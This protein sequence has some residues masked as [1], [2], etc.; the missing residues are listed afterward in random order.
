MTDPTVTS[1]VTISQENLTKMALELVKPTQGGTGLEERAVAAWRAGQGE[2]SLQMIAGE[3]CPWGP[4]DV[5]GVVRE[6]LSSED[7]DPRTG[8]K[9]EPKAGTPEGNR[10]SETEQIALAC[11]EY[12]EKGGEPPNVLVDSVIA[13]LANTPLRDA[14]YNSDGTIK[15]QSEAEAIARALLREQKTRQ[16]MYQFFIDRLDPTKRLPHEQRVQDLRK[17]VNRLRAQ[18]NLG[19][20]IDRQIDKILTEIRTS[21][22]EIRSDKNFAS[23]QQKLNELM[24]LKK[25]Y[26]SFT[27]AHVSGSQQKPSFRDYFPNKFTNIAE[28]HQQIASLEQ[29]LKNDPEFSNINELLS[30]IDTHQKQLQSLHAKKST[31]DSE[32]QKRL[33]EELK[34]KEAELQDAEALLR[35]ERIKYASEI[36]AIPKEAVKAYLNEALADVAASYKEQARKDAQ[37]KAKQEEQK[38]QEEAR[39]LGQAVEKL[40]YALSTKKDRKGV[41]IPNRKMAKIWLDLLHQPGGLEKFIGE[42][43]KDEQTLIGFGLTQQEA[44]LILS[45]KTDPEFINKIVGENLAP[46]VLADYLRAGG[47]LS[48]K[49][50]DSIA[51]SQWGRTLIEKGLQMAQERKRVGKDLM[52]RL[53]ELRANFKS[54]DLLVGLGGIGILLILLLKLG[55]FK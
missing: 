9:K 35:A 40:A 21:E 3:V 7:R 27:A 48:E 28:V 24:S 39:M 15:D 38:K 16:K 51:R 11:Q 44:Q 1:E 30:R 25:A 19:V 49:E 26:E 2:K 34:A 33:T 20:A 4:D 43:A 37:E 52:G 53:D 55:V 13:Y 54:A 14:I 12:L 36:I 22:L 29:S 5:I 45:K 41:H 6:N 8:Q 50:V 18:V 10:C 23:Y 46:S 31:I 47:R 42:V 17:E 32:E